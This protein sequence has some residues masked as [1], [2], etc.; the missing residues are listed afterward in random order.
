MAR[1]AVAYVEVRPDMEK[2][3]TLLEAELKAIHPN[4]H[5]GVETDKSKLDAIQNAVSDAAAKS[6]AAS[7]K[8]NDRIEK[9]QQVHANRMQA[10]NDNMTKHE[11]NELLKEDAATKA[12]NRSKESAAQ[13]SANRIQA[14]ND[15]MTRHEVDEL[16]KEQTATKAVNRSKEAAAQVSANRMQAIN[17]R[18]LKDEF[19]AISKESKHELA[20]RL[21]D[22]TAAN[23]KLRRLEAGATNARIARERGEASRLN[24]IANNNLKNRLRII[25]EGA[26]RRLLIERANADL[27]ART[28]AEDFAKTHVEEWG[29]RVGRVTQ[30]EARAL[31]QAMTQRFGA[32]GGRIA[33]NTVRDFDREIE[34]GMRAAGRRGSNSFVSNLFDRM[35]VDINLRLGRLAP[36]LAL[37]AATAV[38]LVKVLDSLAASMVAVAAAA[39]QML[40]AGGAA[41]VSGLVALAQAALTAKFA[42]TGMGDALKEL[43]DLTAKSAAGVKL[44]QG[45]VDK[46]NMA[47]AKLSPAARDVVGTLGEVHT[48]FAG[49]RKA[50]QQTLL[51]NMSGAVHALA[52]SYLP[53]LRKELGATAG[54]LNKVAQ[55]FVSF[56]TKA[57]TVGRV[58]AIMAGNTA[59][60]KTLGK[61]M[62]PLVNTA[63]RLGQAFLPLGNMLARYVENWA[64][65][66]DRTTG[67]NEAS[68]RLT[69]TVRSMGDALAQ[70]FRITGAVGGALKAT[71]SA[72]L[73]TGRTLMDMLANLTTRWENWAKSVEGQNA[74]ATWAASALPVMKALGRLLSDLFGMWN[75]L[76]QAADAV[77]FVDQIRS[78][79]PPLER[80]LIQFSGSNAIG[81][82]A[83]ALG[84]V[85]TAI[86]DLNIGGVLADAVNLTAGL[87]HA[88]VDLIRTV[89]GAES[90]LRGVVVVLTSL[91]AI[92]LAG[93]LTGL[94]LLPRAIAAIK[95]LAASTVIIYNF[96]RAWLGFSAVGKG[97]EL[98]FALSNVVGSVK[99]FG[100]ALV[101]VA[102]QMWATGSAS[103]AAAVGVRGLTAAIV[104]NPVG[105]AV[106]AITAVVGV[107]WALAA[108]SD[109]AARKVLGLDDALAGLSSPTNLDEIDAKMKELDSHSNNFWHDLWANKNAWQA[110]FGADVAPQIS[111]TTQAIVEQQNALA[112]YQA[113]VKRLKA[114]YGDNFDSIMEKL[115]S[116]GLSSK[117]T[118][119][120]VVAAMS[121]IS[122]SAGKTGLTTEQMVRTLAN[123]FGV[124]SGAIGNAADNVSNA[125]MGMGKAALESAGKQILAHQQVLRA[126]G[127]KGWEYYGMAAL[128]AI[129]EAQMALK[130]EA[131]TITSYKPI[132]S[133]VFTAAG[134]EAAGKYLSSWTAVLSKID[135]FTFIK[136]GRG[137]PGTRLAFDTGKELADYLAKGITSGAK[138]IAKASAYIQRYYAKNLTAIL[139]KSK[140]FWDKAKTFAAAIPDLM[141]NMSSGKQL[142]AYLGKQQAFYEDLL[143]QI[144][145]FKSN[146]IG[147][148]TE[149]ADQV[150]Y[151]GFLPTPEEVKQHL[152]AQLKQIQD[153]TAGIAALQK[154]NLDPKLIQAWME[155]GPDQAGNLVQGLAGAT[156]QQ[157]DAINQSYKAI[158]TT[159]TTAVT[160]VSDQMFGVGQDTVVG[161]INGIK[162][163]RNAAGKEM[164]ALIDFVVQEARKKLKAKSPSQVYDSMGVDT[165]AGYIQ[166]V[167]SMRGATVST[168]NKL[169]DAVR[170][171][172]GA[173]LATPEIGT[174]TFAAPSALGVNAKPTLPPVFEA[175][176]FVGDRE[177]RDIV[178]V[179]LDQVDDARARALYTGRR[180]I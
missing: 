139:N 152:D 52:G 2:F 128:K 100:S 106:V 95:G 129:G 29:K 162:S 119:Q 146:A 62:V 130:S 88:F 178:K 176:V 22:S 90:M 3:A 41:V 101:G 131:S 172:K 56:A 69:T 36:I 6:V 117:V 31:E 145:S 20:E 82:F 166:G 144:T 19:D 163:M 27:A 49:L 46:Y 94:F 71:F 23:N 170:N 136:G 134:K 122:S 108:S 79:L 167:A 174:P 147:A 37:L 39:G 114:V 17:D 1:V 5:V 140:A 175:R 158:G 55:G 84:D 153:F 98:A 13:V 133:T 99:Q 78:I 113:Q 151:F 45:E 142:D 168:V 54:V 66:V 126:A 149:G 115:R 138:N 105:A 57:S 59:I 85:G 81:A 110:V 76:A 124:L 91:A 77:S 159:A 12:I 7:T 73:G 35:K 104:A 75:R 11:V 118:D 30:D 64:K 25:N 179:E 60:I 160:Q 9:A 28:A 171:V 135:P 67:A 161:Y 18:M 34:K 150:N 164:A 111:D 93:T 10:I 137:A 63:L 80:L 53:V 58:R 127:T 177:I 154:K 169:F 32:V 43:N 16:L 103:E 40:A 48:Q 112:P 123:N 61:A 96:T 155:A 102:A 97:G 65:A 33:R 92:R 83:Q 109:S 4:V 24:A 38:P 143:S 180:G 148:L 51:T 74:I 8:A 47:M 165:V 125:Y 156:Q 132:D 70:L 26:R 173:K 121:H 42:L 116:F 21:K 15:K 107:I 120:Q 44:T 50:V 86:A 14:I 89:P 141:K 68:G 72:S 87:F 157:I